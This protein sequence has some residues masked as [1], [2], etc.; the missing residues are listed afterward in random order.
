MGQS[1]IPVLNR[2]GYSMFWSSVWDDVHSYNKLFKEDLFLKKYIPLVFNDKISSRPLFLTN[3]YS[4]IINVK[5]LSKKY[6]VKL[7]QHINSPSFSRHLFKLNKMPNY[8]SKI[9][10]VRFQNWLVIYL[11][12]YTPDTKKNLVFTLKKY[13]HFKSF[14]KFYFSYIKKIFFKKNEFNYNDL[15]SL[16]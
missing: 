4:F 16:F 10:I 8:I 11:Y 2:T 1:S 14:K 12:I 3:K 5:K 15:I 9:Y 6:D 7:L 13:N